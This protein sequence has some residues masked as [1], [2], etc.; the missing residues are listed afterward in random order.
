MSVLARF[1]DGSYRIDSIDGFDAADYPA[2][3]VRYAMTK[4][5]GHIQSDQPTSSIQRAADNLNW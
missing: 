1:I 5:N 2:H 4:L 3:D